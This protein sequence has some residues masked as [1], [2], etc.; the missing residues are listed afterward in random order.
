MNFMNCSTGAVL[1]V[2]A[3]LLPLG[4]SEFNGKF[5]DSNHEELSWEKIR[6]NVIK[7]NEMYA[8]AMAKL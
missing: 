8:T 3:A 1:I 2:F 7:Y 4:R 6:S 5:I